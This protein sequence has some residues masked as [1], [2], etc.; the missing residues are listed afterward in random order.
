[1]GSIDIVIFSE[2][3]IKNINNVALFNQKKW[4][5]SLIGLPD[6]SFKSWIFSLNVLGIVFILSPLDLKAQMLRC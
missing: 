4:S 5:I 3:D 1:K 6:K 2:K